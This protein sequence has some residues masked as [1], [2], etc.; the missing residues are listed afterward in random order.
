MIPDYFGLEELICPHV[1]YKFGNFAWNFFDTR[2]IMTLDAIRDRIGRAIFVNDWHKKGQFSQRGLRCPECQLV[3]D[4]AVAGELYMSAHT[5]GKAVDFEI[6]GMLAEESRKWIIQH[7]EWWPA[8]I[9][10][11]SGVSWVH[12]D[13]Y[14]DG[15]QKKIITFENI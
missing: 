9:R 14:N 13:V 1:Y 12:L 8:A 5:L 10:L 4:K 7:E 15:T 2:L 11:E 3:K 6:Q